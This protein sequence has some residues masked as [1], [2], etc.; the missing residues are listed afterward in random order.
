M[1]CTIV[2]EREQTR[3][4][5]AVSR[6]E[7]TGHAF[8]VLDPTWPQSFLAM[9]A[10]QVGDAASSGLVADGDLVVF[11]SGSTGRPRGIVRTV[12]SWQASVCAL[13]DVTGITAE[14]TVWLPGPLWS[15]LFLY[16]AFHARAV[17]ARLVFGDAEDHGSA[18][19]TAL[20]CVP[21]QLPG[22][23]HRAKAGGLPLLRRV[24]VAGDHGAALL[25]QQCEAAGWQVTEYYGAAELSFVARRDGAG[26]FRDFPGV[27]TE[28]RDGA[29][30]ARSPYLARGYLTD[31]PPIGSASGPVGP[32]GSVGSVGSADE[33]PL[34]FDRQGWATVSDLARVVPGGLEILGRGNSAVSS[35]GHTVVV[36][37]VERHL[38]GLPDVDEVAVLGMPHPRLGQVLTAIVVG[39]A[40]DGDLRAAVAGM[41]A[42]SRPR[43]W[44]HADALPRTSGGKLRRDDLA[45]LVVRLDR[46]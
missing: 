18:R 9:A 27:E 2:Q 41:P 12:E 38:R 42:P 25:R 10:I 21:S 24:V 6:A 8:A 28:V 3:L 14:D 1:T 36:E 22:L 33:G 15:S 13:S 26:P 44:V 35:G 31:H 30:W 4:Y 23:L 37:E 11:S 7:G 43:R 5:D 16:G 29:L 34:R 39:S 17:G 46:R 20:H 19:A 40:P 32:V 45:D